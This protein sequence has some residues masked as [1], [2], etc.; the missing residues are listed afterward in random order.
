M[1]TGT[2]YGVNFSTSGATVS[3]VITGSSTATASK[4]ERINALNTAT[5]TYLTTS[6]QTGGVIIKGVINT[7]ANEGNLSI[8]HLKV[9]SGTSTVFVDSF[10]KV[11]QVK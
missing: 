3:A 6:G 2:K 8:Q 7:G 4:T 1:T 5:G 9:T 11:I 10:L